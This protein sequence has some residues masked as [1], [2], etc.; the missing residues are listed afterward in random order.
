M[1]RIDMH[2]LQ[3]MVRLHRMGTGAHKTAQMLK[4][5]P[6]TERRY[7]EALEKAEMLYGPVD[8]LPPLSALKKIVSEYME[9]K[10][11]VQHQSSV[12]QWVSQIEEMVK[13]GAGPKA[14]YD[15]LQREEEDFTGS[16]Y[17]V[18]RAYNRIRTSHGVC[19]QDVVI[20]VETAPGEVAQ[21]DFGYVGKLY[22]PVEKVLRKAYVFVMVLGF[23]RHQFC[24]IAFD[25]KIETWLKLHV[26]A[27][28]WLGG[29][30]RVVVP[31][32]LKSA[33]IRAVFAMSESTVLNR[34]YCELARHYGFKVDPTPVYSPEKKGKVESGVKYVK[35]NFFKPMT[36]LDAGILGEE[37][38]RWVLQTAGTRIHGTTAKQP[39]MVYEQQER[40]HMLPLPI[41]AFEPVLYKT[42]TVHRDT[43]IL[44][45]KALY[46]VPWRWMGKEVL[47][48][49]TA[50]SITIYGDDVRLAT[51]VRVAPG[52][53]STK[54]EHLPPHRR[55][56]RHRSHSYWV[57]RANRIDQSVERYIREVFDCDDVLEQ[58]RVVQKIVTHLETFPKHR[59]IAACKRARYYS[60]YNYQSIKNI[61]RKGL[62]HQPLPTLTYPKTAILQEPRFARNIQELLDFRKEIN[63]EYN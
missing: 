25:Q 21:V 5:S 26:A 23:S 49:G 24:A 61:L 13:K 10:P 37:L 29:V 20:P 31:D 34:S 33:V 59:A 32:N 15:R 57:E 43:H 44:Y 1:K 9:S 8:A 56:L 18:K 35:N 45:E 16:V 6:N 38:N 40:Q 2:R 17:A 48:R 42:A 47:V 7:R 53:R 46:S 4:M 22:D 51:H 30:P 60:S 63:D 41:Q 55:D 62:D 54:E 52:K 27:F 28:K 3:E 39:L 58:L 36:E 50:H 11:K 19:A 14:I 12:E